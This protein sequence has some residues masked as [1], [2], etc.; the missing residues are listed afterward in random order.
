MKYNLFDKIAFKMAQLGLLGVKGAGKKL[1]DDKKFVGACIKSRGPAELKD[2]SERLRS[3]AD[4]IL[5]NVKKYPRVLE[6]CSEHVFDRYET[7]DGPVE[8]EMDK[9]SFITLC[10]CTNPDSIIYFDE[11]TVN[12]YYNSV[13]NSQ[14]MICRYHGKNVSV[15][16]ELIYKEIN[17]IEE[18]FPQIVYANF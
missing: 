17:W 1:Q 2:A 15:S 6:Y 9:L 10:C 5:T 16:L 4:F 14:S 7:K 8:V 18:Y 13:R 11:R 3:D 12:K